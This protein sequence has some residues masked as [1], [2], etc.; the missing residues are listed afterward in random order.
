[1]LEHRVELKVV[2]W[3]DIPFREVV[4]TAWHQVRQGRV[5]ADSI[6]AAEHLQLLV[7]GAG[8][9]SATVTVHRTVDEALAHV[10]HFE[11]R[12]EPA[13]VLLGR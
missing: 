9:R 8:Y 10:G 5:D 3:D 12:R 11:V 6:T 13:R 2:D 1:M 7:R 4:E